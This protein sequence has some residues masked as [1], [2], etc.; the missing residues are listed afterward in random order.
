MHQLIEAQAVIRP[1]ATALIFNDLELTFDQ[2]NRRANRLA[3]HLRGRGIGPEARV[4]LAMQRSP[5]MIIGLLAI[6]KAGGAYV[7]LDPAYPAERLRYLMDDSGISLLIS[8]SWLRV[9][10]PLPVGLAVLEIVR[11][12]LEFMADS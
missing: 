6:L 12:P 5:E 1:D 8:Q 7:P 3:H 9:I 4:G 10:L 2:L 11:E